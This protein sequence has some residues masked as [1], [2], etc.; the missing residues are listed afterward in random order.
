MSSARAHA[1]SL[2]QSARSRDGTNMWKSIP[3]YNLGLDDGFLKNTQI[4]IQGLSW[5]PLL[6]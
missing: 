6:F 4:N 3:T 5:L 1:V 2:N